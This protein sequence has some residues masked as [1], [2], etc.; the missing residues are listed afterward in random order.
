M[1]DAMLIFISPYLQFC[2]H[3]KGV[4]TVRF[5]FVIEGIKKTLE[6]FQ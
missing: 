6:W 2:F 1:S 3:A 4:M 5:S